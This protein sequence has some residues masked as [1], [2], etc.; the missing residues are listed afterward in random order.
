MMAYPYQLKF[1]GKKEMEKGNIEKLACIFII[2]LIL[3]AFIL[4]IYNVG[5][6]T[7]GDEST[8]GALA[9]YS[10]ESHFNIFNTFYIQIPNEPVSG[11]GEIL[12]RPFAILPIIPFLMTFGYTELSIRLPSVLFSVFSIPLLYLILRKQGFDVR[13]ILM[14]CFLFAILPLNVDF[15]RIGRIESAITFYCLLI[16]YLII[17]G[18][19]DENNKLFYLAGIIV[20]M[21]LLTTTFRGVFP[22]IALVPYI[23][24]ERISKER[25]KHIAAYIFLIISL[26]L[27]YILIPFLC[28][29]T[30]D[31]WSNSIYYFA[32]TSRLQ[33]SGIEM[34]TVLIMYIKYLLFT[35]F[36]ALI[37]LP[38]LMGIFYSL[39]K[40]KTSSYSLWFFWF[41]SGFLMLSIGGAAP[42]RFML[43]TPAYVVLASIGIVYSYSTFIQ[44][45][46][47]G[48]TFP[49][50][51]ASTSTYIL[52]VIYL[53]PYLFQIEWRNM[54]PVLTEYHVLFVFSFITKYFIV[55]VL[56][57]FLISLIFYILYKKEK[58]N[59]KIP[60]KKISIA[61]I[62]IYLLTNVLLINVLVITGVGEFHRPEEVRVV[63]DYLKSNL[64][65]EKY[66]CVAGIHANSFTFY[67]QRMC[68]TWGH[69]DIDWIEEKVK[70]GELR[71]FIYNLY[72]TGIED[73]K[74]DKLHLKR[75]AGDS[76][77]DLKTRY[78]EKYEWL[79]QN[80]I[81]I[82]YKTG[83]PPDN[84]YFRVYEYV[85]ANVN[86]T[87][88][89]RHA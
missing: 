3:Y 8:Y 71:Y 44:R 30:I 67:I 81:E 28:G 85:N 60:I 12:T 73:E 35:P 51:I 59:S 14:S 55:L 36:L 33:Q 6:L 29:K 62:V 23:Y 47:S 34:S 49:L 17:K 80:C 10:I 65:S 83:L 11:S 69:I 63:A 75:G 15:S 70:S 56:L 77:F 4:R 74:G 13:I 40:I 79:T 58:L 43:F 66:G 21:N 27:I 76:K 78:P 64:N 88:N 84:K 20:V 48:F 22:V 38:T 31:F 54:V 72:Q 5:G 24:L 39:K 61:I 32:A 19:K 18:I 57:F 2:A 52:S 46:R 37:A 42:H 87:F 68:P 82:T 25:L 1:E 86:S 16:A 7:G 50:L 41:L 26:L 53:F 9:F 89:G 45:E